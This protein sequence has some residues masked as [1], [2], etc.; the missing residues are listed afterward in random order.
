MFDARRSVPDDVD[1]NGVSVKRPCPI[2]GGDAVC[3]TRPDG[4]FACCARRTSDWPLTNG[5]WL[6]RLV[7]SAVGARGEVASADT[8]ERTRSNRA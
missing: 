2:C 5:L 8:H 3:R 6:H 4:T 1:W 7:I